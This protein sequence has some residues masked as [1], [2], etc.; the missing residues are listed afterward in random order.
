[1]SIQDTALT[2]ALA[3][4]KVSGVP[5][6]VLMPSGDTTITE[7]YEFH[8]TAPPAPPEPVKGKRIQTVPRGTYKAVHFPILSTMQPGDTRIIEVPDHLDVEGL[9]SS[10]CG[11]ASVNWGNDTYLTECSKNARTFTIARIL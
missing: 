5:Y 10:A 7:G 9:R 11:W 8:P 4:L 3:L 6:A 2:R 1:M